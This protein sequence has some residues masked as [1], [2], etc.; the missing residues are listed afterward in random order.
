MDFLGMGTGEI[1]LIIIVALIIWGPNRIVEIARTLGKVVYRLRNM[2]ADLSTAV[3]K[4]IDLAE[5]GH[6]S[7]TKTN[8]DPTKKSSNAGEAEATSPKDDRPQPLA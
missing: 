5:K 8:N 1:L 6:L 3:T 7:P 2:T 4:E